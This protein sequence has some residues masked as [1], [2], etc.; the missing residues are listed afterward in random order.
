MPDFKSREY[1]AYCDKK[2]RDA[3][4]NI[5]VNFDLVTD[6]DIIEALDRVSNMSELVRRA[7]R[8]YLQ[9]AKSKS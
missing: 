7:L 4:R 2:F 3:H 9:S 5:K 8:F 1:R 6:A